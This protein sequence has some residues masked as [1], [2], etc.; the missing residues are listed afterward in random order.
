MEVASI[1]RKFGRAQSHLSDTS[2]NKRGRTTARQDV[3]G[4]GMCVHTSYIF[5]V[6]TT[7]PLWIYGVCITL[8]NEQL[9]LLKFKSL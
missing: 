6:Y 7:I 1:S 8:L 3:K 2:G 4:V 9:K 5:F